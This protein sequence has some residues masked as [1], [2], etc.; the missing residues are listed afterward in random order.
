MLL[1]YEQMGTWEV[2]DYRGVDFRKVVG[3]L[4]LGVVSYRYSPCAIAGVRRMSTYAQLE[5]GR[6]CMK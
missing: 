4:G 3:P 2:V 1:R 5:S 6:G